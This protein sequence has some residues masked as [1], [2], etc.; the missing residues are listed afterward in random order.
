MTN[1]T[2]H[3]ATD[4]TDEQLT[5]LYDLLDEQ[6]LRLRAVRLA[7]EQQMRVADDVKPPTFGV[8]EHTDDERGDDREAKGIRRSI[9]AVYGALQGHGR[10]EPRIPDSR[11]AQPER[12]PPGAAPFS[13][14]PAQRDTS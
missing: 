4:I 8:R 6:R 2:R 10:P 14:L 5:H 12:P 3:G 7:C 13:G 9:T 11:R 1:P